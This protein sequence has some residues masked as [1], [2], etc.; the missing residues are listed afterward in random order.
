IRDTGVEQL[1]R[2]PIYLQAS[3]RLIEL[4]DPPGLADVQELEAE[5]HRRT[6]E[7]SELRRSAADVQG[8]RWAL[9]ELRV[10]LFAQQLRAVGP[11]SVK[12]VRRLL[13]HLPQL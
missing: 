3:R 2:L 7:L 10:S 1:A 4:G 9:E 12:R 13:D 11:V 6:A 5:F 8:V